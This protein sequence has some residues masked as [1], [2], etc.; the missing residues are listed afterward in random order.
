M[1]VARTETGP[2]NNTKLASSVFAQKRSFL[3]AV[4]A[5][6]VK[7]VFKSLSYTNK[8]DQIPT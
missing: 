8:I 1:K 4:N 7:L 3:L 2:N 6:S 5:I